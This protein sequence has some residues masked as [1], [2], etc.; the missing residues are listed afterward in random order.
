MIGVLGGTFDPIHFGHLRPA[1]EIHEQLQLDQLHF[2]PSNIPP[3][4]A[5]PA[6]PARHRLAM[7]EHAIAGVPGF[8]ADRRELDRPGPSYT[9]DTLRDLRA[10]FGPDIPLVLILGMD[11]FAGLHTWNRWREIPRLA[12]VLA[13]HRPGSELAT[14][15]PFC[16]EMVLAEAPA[17]LRGRACGRVFFQGVTQLDISATRIRADLRRGLSPRYLL[18]DAVGAYIIEHGLYRTATEDPS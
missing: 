8:R 4:R 11:A 18:P 3:H 16:R 1:L 9:V 5:A 10:E 7:L 14:D 2:V 15:A 17:D 12:H 6:I 13:A